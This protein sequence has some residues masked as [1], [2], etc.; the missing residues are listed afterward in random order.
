MVIRHQV[1]VLNG[2]SKVLHL[3]IYR[4]NV[5]NDTT[6]NLTGL[7]HFLW[8]W[9]ETFIQLFGMG[10]L[11]VIA[12]VLRKSYIENQ[13]HESLHILQWI[14]ELFL[15]EGLIHCLEDQIRHYWQWFV[16]LV[17]CQMFVLLLV[18]LHENVLVE[19]ILWRGQWGPIVAQ[20]RIHKEDFPVCVIQRIYWELYLRYLLIFNLLDLLVFNSLIWFPLVLVNLIIN[21]CRES[22]NLHIILLVQV[23]W[24]DFPVLVTLLLGNHAIGIFRWGLVDQLPLLIFFQVTCEIVIKVIWS[25]EFLMII[26]YIKCIVIGWLHKWLTIS[27]IDFLLILNEVVPTVDKGS[28]DFKLIKFQLRFEALADVDMAVSRRHIS[29]LTAQIID[30]GALTNW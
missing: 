22:V 2:S 16:L 7:L 10:V 28:W 6:S 5:V 18:P 14:G 17:S 12:Q 19:Q 21:G 15:R 3:Y 8:I 23:D 30:L 11:L 13:F 4:L 29:I 20:G 27:N 1:I 25:F 9:E 26:N 24:V